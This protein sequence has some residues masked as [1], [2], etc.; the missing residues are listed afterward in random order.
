VSD[1][2]L[3]IEESYG[4]TDDISFDL[5]PPDQIRYVQ[6]CAVSSGGFIVE[7]GS[8]EPAI[9]L[10]VIIS[11]K[12]HSPEDEDEEIVLALIPDAAHQLAEAMHYLS[13]NDCS[14]EEDDE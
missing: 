14:E 3:S 11:Q 12:S 7:D 13:C 1:E 4:E 6:N 2:P 8:H 5:I 10:K 9:F